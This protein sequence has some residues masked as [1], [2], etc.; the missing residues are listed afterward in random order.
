M[1]RQRKHTELDG[2]YRSDI[3]F[4]IEEIAIGALAYRN[5]DILKDT[6]IDGYSYEELGKKY[7]LS[8]TRVKTI[9]RRFCA[10][11]AI[12]RNKHPEL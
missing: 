2:L 3:L 4:L 12:Y 9:V 11:V 7:K 1:A 8:K 6:L 5:K 10:D